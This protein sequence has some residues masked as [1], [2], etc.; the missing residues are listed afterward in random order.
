LQVP[1]WIGLEW[2]E[3]Y[4]LE[5]DLLAFLP[6]PILAYLLL[7]PLGDE[8]ASYRSQGDKDLTGTNFLKSIMSVDNDTILF[9]S[10]D[11]IR[12]RTLLRLI[13]IKQF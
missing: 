5:D 10:P 1:K 6:Q 2:N 8:D 4:G 9:E 11:E 7:F 12:L 3:V 13:F